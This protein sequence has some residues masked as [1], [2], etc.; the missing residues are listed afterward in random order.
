[1]A[2]SQPTPIA[3][4]Q[5]TDYSRRLLAAQS[6]LY[7]D[8]KRIHDVRVATVVV[9]A[10]ATV[11]LALTL[12]DLRLVV[13]TIG[14]ALTFL[15]SI[16]ASGREKRRRR[17]AVYVQEEFDTHVFGL[18]WNNFAADHP[19]PTVIVESAA[20]YRGNRTK[21]WYPDT[22]NVVRPL[23][24]LICQRS[25][26]G[27]GSSMHRLY[28]ACLTGAVV[29]LVVAG[30]VVAL[31]ARLSAADALTA[32]LIPF[33]GPVRELVEMV[34]ANRDSG[35]MKA[36]TEAKVLDLWSRGLK[37]AGAVTI[38]DC[39]AVQDRILSI[40][41]SNAHVPDWLDNIRRSHNEALMQES[42][43]HMI[44]EAVRHGRTY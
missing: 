29:L 2:S 43:E 14:G 22:R 30:V 20:R 8:A 12:P 39:R 35:D 7:T 18:P 6:R 3:T 19:S 32:V 33:L 40:R 21:D 37:D 42:A 41:Q 4:A 25:N 1:M 24:V 23:D 31:I 38:D 28:A 15:W 44:E 10:I 26:L 27:W 34:Q 9:L 16:M 13:G 36:K 17:E 5:N 11:A